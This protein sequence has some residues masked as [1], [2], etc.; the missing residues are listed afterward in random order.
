MADDILAPCV[1]RASAAI[2]LT[3]Q[4]EDIF[5]FDKPRFQLPVSSKGCIYM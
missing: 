4:D 3:M 2:V 5:V 1:T